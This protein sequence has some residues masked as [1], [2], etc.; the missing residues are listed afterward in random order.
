MPSG[1]PQSSPSSAE[2]YV[3]SRAIE[4]LAHQLALAGSALALLA[5]G[6][7]LASLAAPAGLERAVAAVV[8]AA[9]IAVLEALLL[10]L[11][12]LGSSTVALGLAAGLGWVAAW[13]LLPAPQ[14]PLLEELAAAANGLDPRSRA[15]AGAALGALAA[16][17]LWL[18]HRPSLGLDGAVYH[19]TEVVMWVRQ[20]TP[21]SVELITYEFPVGNYPVTNEVLLTWAAGLSRSLVP[22]VLWA[23]FCL[24]LAAAAGWLGLRR[25][26]VPK[27]PAAVALACVLAL[28][29][30]F[31]QLRGP[32]TDIPAFAWL[33]SCASLAVCSARRPALL[34]PALVAAGLAV[35]TK[36]TTLPFATL[37]LVVAGVRNRDSLRGL[38]P[39]LGVA[40]VA[41]LGAG[42]YWFAR[43][44]VDHG[45]PFWPFVA[46]PW[47]D[48]VPSYLERFRPSLLERPR[49]TL[50]G[51][52]GDYLEFLGGGPL[53]LACALAAALAVRR[54]AIL[55][56]GGATAAGLLLW[57][58]SPYTGNAE[59]NDVLDL[60][61]STSRYLL[62]VFGA[63]ALT[64][65]LTARGR[66]G[67]A[68]AAL[69]ALAVCAAWSVVAAFAQG[70]PRVPS[71]LVP[72]AGA[73][74]G[75]ALAVAPLRYRPSAR[76]SRYAPVLVATAA[77]VLI[78]LATPGF[79]DR[80][81]EAQNIGSGLVGWA[82]STPSFS[83]GSTPVAFA[84]APIGVLAGAGLR[85]ELEVVPAREPC[86]RVRARARRGLVVIRRDP[87]QRFLHPSTAPRCLRGEPPLMDD[88]REFRVY[89]PRRAR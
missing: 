19:L 39:V 5:T 7:R 88:G 67:A 52:V 82:E 40:A 23:P 17:V 3:S 48:P 31:D 49:A 76:G 79:P 36:T 54:G 62:P 13:R 41:A 6:V 66:G 65:A 43:N 85:H 72:L 78:A 61:L 68:R 70:F 30:V 87:H 4:V 21:G 29:L 63:A 20:G 50:D 75:A 69:V 28:P 86:D 60:S 14:R 59:V 77:A 84:P 8:L 89:G 44:L 32:G 56:A 47:G 35:G 18:V 37:A 15:A 25:L 12:A 81:A 22:I 27:A 80:Y 73:A 38:A 51:R 46:A 2:A 53:L 33:V 24:A 11:V 9:A 45:S 83:D 1:R 55:A 58:R 71:A 57:A 64:L 26:N 10:G 74:V 34:A 16:Y 42:G